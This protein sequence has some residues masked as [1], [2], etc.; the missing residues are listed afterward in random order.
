M[1]R[2]EAY[3]DGKLTEKAIFSPDLFYRAS[4]EDLRL[5]G[6]TLRE[7]L[8]DSE[9]HEHFN[10]DDLE[11]N[12]K[13]RESSEMFEGFEEQ[14]TTKKAEKFIKKLLDIDADYS[15]LPTEVANDMNQ[16]LVRA[17]NMFGTVGIIE[18]VKVDDFYV[19]GARFAAY[20]PKT[21]SI[22]LRS[23]R[24]RGAVLFAIKQLPEG[25]LS[26]RSEL[27]PY[28]HEIGHAFL[29]YFRRA[30][31]ERV[32]LVENLYREYFKNT[33]KGVEQLSKYAG[34]SPSEMIAEA[35]AEIMNGNPR[36]FALKILSTLLGGTYDDRESSLV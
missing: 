23:D 2:Y 13:K 30:V 21:F 11:E 10:R 18:N 28:R 25:D 1:K 27:H 35:F 17:F 33:R 9:I 31:P 6:K 12:L 20:D 22:L 26:T 3:K 32:E 16:E 4:I 29:Q 14:K 24:G 5:D 36:E 15:K 8:R 34:N 19:T 7:T